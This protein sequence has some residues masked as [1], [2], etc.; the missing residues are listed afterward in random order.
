MK[1]VRELR[2]L[3]FLLVASLLNLTQ[4]AQSQTPNTDSPTPNAQ[5][6][7]PN[8]A[9]PSTPLSLDEAVAFALKASPTAKA[10]LAKLSGAAARQQGAKAYAPPVFTLAQPFGKNTGGLDEDLLVTGTF[11]LGDKRRQ[12][13]RSARAEFEA[14]KSDVNQSRA[15][16]TLAAQS[17]YF[18]TLRAE[19]ERKLAL[20]T[21]K[22]AQ[23]FSRVSEI[24][25][26]AGV[27][28]RTETIRSKIEIDRAEQALR[29][30]ET[31][32]NNRLATLK[33]LAGIPESSELDLTGK[34]EYIPLSVGLSALMKLAIT[35][36]ADLKS[37]LKLRESKVAAL[38]GARVQSLPDL[39]VEARHSTIDPSV[40]GNSIRLGIQFP[41]FDTGKNR[42]AVAE[43]TAAV[44]EQTALSEESGRAIKLEVSTAFRNL[45]GA[46]KSVESFQNGRLQMS[47][48]LLDLAQIGY[49]KRANT[50]LELLD[51][52]QLY[53]TEQTDYARALYAYSLAK[54]ALQHAVGGTLPK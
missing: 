33:S 2:F 50:Y 20:E 54:V 5:R 26:Q 42:A 10:G 27:V 7:T 45:E 19:A 40:G 53:R 21:L 12:R 22:T 15:D 41:L 17:A 25:Y 3:S 43:A 47:K 39:I 44:K 51:A 4:N 38:H 24:Q 32:R 28:A 13:I 23:E 31:D 6:Q 11:E 8:T 52:Q 14:A 16:I 1:R 48:E 37:S 49:E 36:R 29:A 35:N 34:L 18:E 9:T 46:Q 30:T